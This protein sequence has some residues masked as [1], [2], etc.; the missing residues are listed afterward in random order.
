MAERGDDTLWA[1]KGAWH[2]SRMPSAFQAKRPFKSLQR[3]DSG[4]SCEPA[5]CALAIS[6]SHTRGSFSD[7]AIDGVIDYEYTCS[8]MEP[9]SQ[10]SESSFRY[11]FKR[12]RS[13]MMEAALIVGSCS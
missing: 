10:F 5:D 13:T 12:E 1:L 6:R 9:G 2:R 7:H 3:A 8:T 4:S 11:R